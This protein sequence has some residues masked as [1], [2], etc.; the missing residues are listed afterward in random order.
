MNRP[1]RLSKAH[2]APLLLAWFEE[3]RRAF[4]WRET[5]SAYEI[6]VAEALLQK[7]AAINALPV[8]EE[9]LDRY[10]SV[11]DLAQADYNIVRETL[12]PLGLPARSRHLHQL[13]RDVVEKYNGEFPQTE[14]D[15]RELPGA[16]P[17]GAAAIACQAFGERAPMIDINVMRVFHRVFSVPF[18]P[19]NAPTK[20]LR[21]LVLEYMPEG[22]PQEYN[23]ALL[24]LGALLCH[25]RQPEC[26]KC[27]ISE[28]CDYY[29]RIQS[30]T[31]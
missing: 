13:A 11:E 18:K 31:I 6:A 1:A 5:T 26:S 12:Q 9:F 3:N 2:F 21:A 24:D 23:L 19:R 17:Y 28:I 7:T 4:P 16:G 29:I 8:Y 14:K 30:V 15:L 22:K 25:S 20:A 10:P 27:P